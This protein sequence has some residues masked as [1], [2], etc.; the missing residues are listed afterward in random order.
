MRDRKAARTECDG[1]QQSSGHSHVLHKVNELV[2]IGE[3]CVEKYGR[4]EREAR[5]DEHGET[6]CKPKHG[7]GSTNQLHRGSCPID[8]CGVRQ[9]R[10]RD[11]GLRFSWRQQPLARKIA[12]IKKRPIA[13]R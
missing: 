11:I 10:G 2:L 8:S 7:K 3:M 13:A 12:A 4:C 9:A 1:L 6:C 5:K